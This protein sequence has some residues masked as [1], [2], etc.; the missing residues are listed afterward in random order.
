MAEL[1]LQV[2]IT[3]LFNRYS[4]AP[5]NYTT[6]GI[7]IHFRPVIINNK[8]LNYTLNIHIICPGFEY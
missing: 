8:H 7:M 2:F 3:F 4:G 5:Y 6:I 1:A